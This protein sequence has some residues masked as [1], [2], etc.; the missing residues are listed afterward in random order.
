MG[1]I[2]YFLQ[3]HKHAYKKTDADSVSKTLKLDCRIMERISSQPKIHTS[4]KLSEW[5]VEVR[6]FSHSSVSI[7]IS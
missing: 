3:F 2:V 1:N 5:H 7:G 6:F 4:T